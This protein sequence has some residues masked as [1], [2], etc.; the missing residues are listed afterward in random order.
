[1]AV[2]EPFCRRWADLWENLRQEN[3]PLRALVNGRMVSV[4]EDFYDPYLLKEIDNLS[5]KKGEFTVGMA[6]GQTLGH[7]QF[8]VWDS[9]Y[10][11]RITRFLEQGMLEVVREPE[12]GRVYSRMLTKG[13]QAE[14]MEACKSI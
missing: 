10:A 6:V 4:P 8:G 3:A 12:D 14:D 9:W 2:P 7:C 1:M 5:A 13:Q 11:L